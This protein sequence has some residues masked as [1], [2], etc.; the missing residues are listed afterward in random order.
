MKLALEPHEQRVVDEKNE[1]DMKLDRLNHYITSER[2]SFSTL[3]AA[4][5]DRLKQQA[6][7]MATYSDILGERIAAFPLPPQMA[8]KTSGTVELESPTA[9]DWDAPST[10]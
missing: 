5:Q 7:I 9:K 10:N 6:A 2:S 1:L 4:E 3:D 8:P